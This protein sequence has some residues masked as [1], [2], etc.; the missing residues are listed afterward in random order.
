MRIMSVLLSLFIFGR[1]KKKNTVKL[2]E[3]V[4]VYTMNSMGVSCGLV[5]LTCF[6][7]WPTAKRKIAIF[8]FSCQLIVRKTVFFFFGELPYHCQECDLLIIFLFFL[9]VLLLFSQL[10]FHS[11][12]Q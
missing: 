4:V 11:E 9:F 8:C 1:S 7:L 12:P 10:L 3:C 5:G 2:C 6:K